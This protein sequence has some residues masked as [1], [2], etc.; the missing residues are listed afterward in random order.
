[1]IY[2]MGIISIVLLFIVLGPFMIPDTLWPQTARDF[3]QY[4]GLND[5]GAS[6][7]VSAI[8]LGYRAYDTIGETIVLLAAV[9]GALYL[10]K[11]AP[12]PQ[13]GIAQPQPKPKRRT[14]IIGLTTG[15][16]A[17]VVMLFGWYVMFFGHL[18]PGG[19]FQGGVVLASGML[20]IALGREGYHRESKLNNH[21]FHLIEVLSLWFLVVLVCIPL[22]FGASILE[23][24]F[25]KIDEMLPRV[26]YVISFN[27][28]IGLKVASG[29]TLLG[30]LMMDMTHD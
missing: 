26:I 4:N 9:T 20:F 27:M 1:M 23:N 15:K 3:L 22:A 12:L 10:I 18:S 24:P 8:Y 2:T 7:L 16:L 11:R 19:G 17:P 5:T 30:L 29:L 6:N 28:A 14:T 25:T 13:I 21:G